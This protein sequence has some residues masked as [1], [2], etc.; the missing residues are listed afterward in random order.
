MQAKLYFWAIIPI[1]ILKNFT[2]HDAFQGLMEIV[3]FKKQNS[4]RVTLL[5]GNHELH[6]YFHQYACYRFDPLYF[7]EYKAILTGKETADMF[8]VCKQIDNYLFIHAG[9]TKGWMMRTKM[10]C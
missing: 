6:Y 5:I 7:V 8:R 4:D 1:P 3:D 2:Q 9:I 10:N